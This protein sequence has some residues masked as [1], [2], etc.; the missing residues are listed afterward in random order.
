MQSGKLYGGEN[1][2]MCEDVST[3]KRAPATGARTDHRL[4]SS[5]EDVKIED[6]EIERMASRSPAPPPAPNSDREQ[7]ITRHE[8]RVGEG[9]LTFEENNDQRQQNQIVNVTAE[10]GKRLI[11]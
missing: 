4:P 2:Q 6:N 10:R 1:Q 5:P 11:V 3:A 7:N 9:G 8:W